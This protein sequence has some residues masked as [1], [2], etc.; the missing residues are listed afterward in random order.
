MNYYKN[1][2]GYSDPTA[3]EA[4]MK[5][6]QYDMKKRNNNYRVKRRTIRKQIGGKK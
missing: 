3:G 2:E 4:L 1:D 6:L 5:I